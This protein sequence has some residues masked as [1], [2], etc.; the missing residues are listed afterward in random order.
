MKRISDAK[1]GSS[2]RQEEVLIDERPLQ[3]APDRE[4]L[5][6]G[7]F[8]WRKEELV[9]WPAPRVSDLNEHLVE[10]PV[11]MRVLGAWPKADF[12]GWVSVA[13]HADYEKLKEE[14]HH[15]QYITVQGLHF[16]HS[17]HT[18]N[19]EGVSLSGDHWILEDCI[20]DWMNANGVGIGSNYQIVRRNLIA[21]NGQSGIGNGANTTGALIEDN[22]T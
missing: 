5:E 13:G 4:H 14:L 21:H 7:S 22:Y 6:P 15:L 9:V 16:R 10:V 18:L 19:R 1:Y 20:V 2:A 17:R 12:H 8:C 11:L 3:W